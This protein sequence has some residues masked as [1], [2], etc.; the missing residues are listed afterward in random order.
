MAKAK[1]AVAAA[2]KAKAAEK[3]EPEPVLKIVETRSEGG[4]LF[5]TVEGTNLERLMSYEARNLAYEERLKHGLGNAGIEPR[6][7][8]YV[9]D[10]EL[11]AAQDEKRD[12]QRWRREFAL[13]QML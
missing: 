12:V 8:T 4:K 6:G 13:T 2:V 10:T 7:G 5:I 11:K 3:K 9:D 1:T